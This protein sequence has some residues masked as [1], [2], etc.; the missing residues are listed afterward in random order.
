MLIMKI[1]CVCVYLYLNKNYHHFDKNAQGAL[2]STSTVTELSCWLGDCCCITHGVPRR[3]MATA[4]RPCSARRAA[5]IETD[6]HPPIGLPYL[7]WLPCIVDKLNFPR[8][9]L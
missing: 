5:R 8:D 1:V 9:Y 2:V 4:S 3:S 6:C 7:D